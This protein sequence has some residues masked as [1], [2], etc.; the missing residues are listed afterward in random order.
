VYYALAPDRQTPLEEQAEAFDI[1]YRLGKFSRLGICNFQP[2]MLQEWINI[3]NEKGYIKPTVFQG[4]YNL[5]C[6]GYET[7]LFPLLRKHGI[8]FHAFAVLAGGMLT[9]K[10]TFSK[11]PDDLKG[12]RFEV[13]E[14]NV[15]GSFGRKWYDKPC[16]HDAIRQMAGL[17][18]AYGVKMADAALRWAM[19]HSVLAGGDAIIIGPR[20]EEQL[21]QNIT[22]LRGGP[23]PEELVD[24]LNGLWD[25]VKDEALDMLVY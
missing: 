10:V 20:N 12:T 23:L 15:I 3:A 18:D 5:L 2:E 16:F 7:E 21:D 17:C 25:G 4:Q 19:H 22:A 8:S 9:G 14:T 11:G 1:Q 24:R 6:R 13:S